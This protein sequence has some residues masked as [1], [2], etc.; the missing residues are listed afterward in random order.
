MIFYFDSPQPT[1]C[2]RSILHSPQPMNVRRK[3]ERRK[4]SPL[5]S[6]PTAVDEIWASRRA[7]ALPAPFAAFLPKS[8]KLGQVVSVMDL[9]AVEGGTDRQTTC[10]LLLGVLDL[11]RW[12]ESGSVGRIDAPSF[13]PPFSS[14]SQWRNKTSTEVGA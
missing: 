9:S 11:R 5:P 7:R 8:P 3:V 4:P 6:F 13:L 14:S 1:R 2:A 10:H 12:W